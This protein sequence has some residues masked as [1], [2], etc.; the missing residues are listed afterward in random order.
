MKIHRGTMAHWTIYCAQNYFKPVIDYLGRL[1][2][3]R[4]FVAADE[5]PIQVLKEEGHRAQTKSYVWLF[6][7]GEDGNPPIILFQLVLV[8]K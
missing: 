2:N 4:R 7:S 8:Y 6:R 3:Q 1:L 5:T